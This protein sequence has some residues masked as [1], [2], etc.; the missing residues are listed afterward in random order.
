MRD[1]EIARFVFRAGFSTAEAVTSVSGR[2]VGMDVVR[3]NIERIGGSV[4]LRTTPGAGT[5]VSIR[6]PLTLAIV[7]ALVVQ[8]AGERFAV[9]QS[10][11]VELVRVGRGGAEVEWID[12]APVLRLRGALL[13]LAP[14]GALLG[15]ADQPH[16]GAAVEGFVAVL[17]SDSCR[18][19]LLV[20][21]VFDTEE[22]V[23]KPVAPILRDL[24]AFS[25]NTILG[26]GGVIMILDPAGVARMSGLRASGLDGAAQ[27]GDGGTDDSAQQ[28]LVFR[29]GGTA[30]PIAV[31]LGLVARLEALPAR[32]IETAGGQP[33]AQYRD[34]LMPLV[35]L[36]PWSPPAEGR[37]QPVLVFQ[38][39]ERRLGLVVDEI[40]DVLAE[41]VALRP[42]AEREGYLGSAVIAG[43]ATDLLD[44]AFWLRLGDP[45]W[46]G[47][48]GTVPPRVLVVEDS[49]FF[50]QVVV[51][52]LAS[53]GYDV[54]AR[55]D[56]AAALRLRDDGIPFDVVLTDIEM[57]GMDGFG[58]LSEIRREGPWA[59]MPVVALTSRSGP[60]DVARGLAAG[61]AD[62]VPKFDRDRVLGALARAT[63]AK[64]AA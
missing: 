16:G 38:D 4:E 11:V 15:L 24:S 13:P 63:V 33:V 34:R 35:P 18:Y 47:R 31:P 36:G 40:L 20:D 9:P 19:G 48:A 51:P 60:T 22:I 27:Q 39:G 59:R 1:D 43:R 46:F 50:R 29:A 25:G 2:G 44:C 30:T 61:F 5:T 3:S 54:T 55:N 14:L 6:I 21:T 41:K 8:A 32:A 37:S 57:P 23:V 58:L 45:G 49:S 28:L 56:A 26:D 42:S 7:S 10:A 53:A 12:A 62:Y 17:R 52:A 64:E